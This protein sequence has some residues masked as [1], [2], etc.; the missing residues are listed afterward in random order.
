MF[1]SLLFLLLLLPFTAISQFTIT[2]KIINSS[3]KTPVAS[4]S[5]FL[6]NAVVGT[7]TNDDGTFTLTGVRLGQYDLVVSIV[8]Y[9]TSH[10]NVMVNADVKL[11]A[12]EIVSKM[13][14]LK[15]VR[16]KS[17]DDWAKNYETFKRYFFGESEYAGQCKILNKNLPD[18]LD[19]DYDRQ[20]KTFTAKSSD[21]LE[22]E[23]K[24]LGYKIRYMLSD[25]NRDDKTGDFYYEG[26]TLFE[27]LKGSKS[28]IRKWK[29]NRLD[30]Y[31][32]SSMRFL[33]STISNTLEDEGFKALRLIRK[34]NPAYDGFNAKFLQTL[35]STPLTIND[36]VKLTN[37]PGTFALSFTDCLYIIYNKKKA[38][39]QDKSISSSK[40]SP[41]FLDD[42]LTTTLIFN[43]PYSLYDNNGIIINPRSLVFDGNWGNRLVA[44]LLPVDYVP[45]TK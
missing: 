42:P 11:P 12:I 22:I 43:G 20:T 45:E 1:K 34:P 24:A 25:F 29:K 2:G 13:I 44:E 16:I 39:R 35:V 26:T 14:L 7:K 4:A 9:E 27:E 31:E 8:G 6:N 17:K 5:V 33:R 3:D 10:Q 15:E 30:A 41:E 28:Q 37:E 18:I 21:Y 38:H 23:N 32:G 19:L 40:S 36:F